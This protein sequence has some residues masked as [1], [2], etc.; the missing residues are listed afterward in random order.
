MPRPARILLTSTG[1]R[2]DVQPILAL[3]LSL[4]ALGQTCVLCVR[5]DFK[6]WIESYGFMCFSV[7]PSLKQ[8]ARRNARPTSHRPTWREGREIARHTH[9]EQR[10]VLERA[11]CGCDLMLVAGPRQTAARSIAEAMK[12]PYIFVAYSPVTLSGAS[13]PPPRFR[14][15]ARSQTLPCWLNRVLWRAHDWI[16]NALFRRPLNEHRVGIGLAAVADVSSH[17]ATD[18]PWVAADA[19]L[20]PVVAPT[21]GRVTQT[22][23]WLLPDATPLPESLEQFL[24]RCSDPPIYFGFGSTSVVR[25]AARIVV[26]AAR[27]LRRR[28]ILLRGWTE[29]VRPDDQSDC[30]LIDDV[31]YERLFPRLAAVVHH[32]GAGTTNAVARAGKP[33]LIIPHVDDQ[34]YWAHRVRCLGIGT[35]LPDLRSLSA[36][37]VAAA[38]RTCLTPA[39]TARAA[40]LASRI[41]L[42]GAQRAAE[43]LVQRLARASA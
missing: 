31:N 35:A 9:A 30:I 3:A 10:R 23:A 38:L 22:G 17:V 39:M 42:H 20:G 15:G 37:N 43:Q 29:L 18:Q 11:A 16:W 32:G 4:Q 41:D 14:P 6:A 8:L 7:G 25:D 26:A 5:P 40:A 24:G 1:T 2:G 28:A 34:F 19:V 13:H 36:N 12:I 33:Q 21:K 27:S